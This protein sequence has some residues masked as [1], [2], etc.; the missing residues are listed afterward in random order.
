MITYWRSM[1]IHHCGINFY[2]N[3]SHLKNNQSNLKNKSKCNQGSAYEACNR[4]RTPPH[5][6][7]V[8]KVCNKP[9]AIICKKGNEACGISI[10]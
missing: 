6:P 8:S 1:H 5:T 9:H 7:K 10:R 3:Q 4:T 2:P